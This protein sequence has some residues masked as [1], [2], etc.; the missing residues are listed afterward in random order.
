M[1]LERELLIEERILQLLHHLGIQ[2]AHFAA[3]DPGDWMGLASSYPDFITSLTLVCPNTIDPDALRALAP[4][5]LVFTGDGDSRT[6][7]VKRAV[8]STPDATLVTFPGYVSPAWADA[9]ADY[10][11]E[12][13]STMMDFLSRMESRQGTPA[14]R[15]PEEEEEE[16]AGISYRIKGSGPPLVLFPQ[17]LANSQ[18]EPVLDLLSRRYSTITLGG[19]ELGFVAVLETRGHSPGYLRAVRNLI[20]EAQIRPSEAVLDVGCGTGVLDR[21]LAGQ[22]SGNSRIVGMDINRYLLR[23]A[24]S[25]A[26]REGLEGAIEFREGTAEALP[27]PDNS[28]DVS[29]S[30]TVLE[31]GD[32]D[33]MLAELVRVT[34]PGGRVAVM[35]RAGDI[36]WLVNVPLRAELKSKLETPSANVEEQGCADASLYL[37]FQKAS[38]TQVKMFP[39]M[40][41]FDPP[42]GHMG[43]FLE[44]RIIGN[45][46]P[47]EREEWQVAE[48]QA[49]AEGT[50]FYAWPHHCAVGT[51]PGSLADV[52]YVVGDGRT[53]P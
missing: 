17:S 1:S 13:S 18:W 44:N 31:E 38:L 21:W 27:F 30:V 51:S 6:Q 5:L 20:D 3:R 2:R 15:V 32:A 46:S 26:R 43:Q 48:A 29:M 36:P 53:P 35:V 52:G 8:E 4:R 41:A 22:T 23:E 19:A 45:M 9:I 10:P 11:G 24:A 28:F 47:E 40:V 37:R 12:I 42:L 50:F 33:R 34:R 39:Q 7:G 14:L 25:L 16:I 49:M